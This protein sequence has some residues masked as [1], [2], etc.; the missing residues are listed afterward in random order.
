MA[1]WGLYL[2]LLP[3]IGAYYAVKYC[4]PRVKRFY[5]HPD[6]AIRLK[7]RYYTAVGVTAV[8]ALSAVQSLAQAQFA[9]A[10]GTVA[11]TAISAYWMLRERQRIAAGSAT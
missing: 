2:A 8:L 6:P 3:L 4:Y 7:R 11:L 5:S 9:S 10:F 1:K